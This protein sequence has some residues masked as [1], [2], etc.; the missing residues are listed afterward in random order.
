MDRFRVR[1]QH[2]GN[3]IVG[4]PGETGCS[5]AVGPNNQPFPF[6]VPT[7]HPYTRMTRNHRP[8]DPASSKGSNTPNNRKYKVLIGLW[9]RCTQVK[10]SEG[11]MMVSWCFKDN[12]C[13]PARRRQMDW[14]ISFHRAVH[15][16]HL[17]TEGILGP[18]SSEYRWWDS[19][20]G[21]WLGFGWCVVTED[22]ME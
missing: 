10:T 15:G 7:H 6:S 19:G 13:S 3:D 18:L 9:K 11:Q 8:R 20:V 2:H 16:K 22:D 4:G 21:V 1:V 12:L 5:V 17:G 14:A